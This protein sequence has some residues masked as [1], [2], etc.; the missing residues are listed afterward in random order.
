M[1]D[2]EIESLLDNIPPQVQ[3]VW[4]NL[5]L[6]TK[7]RFE[8]GSDKEDASNKDW[9]ASV[10]IKDR[11]N[12]N[13]M[14]GGAPVKKPED[15]TVEDF[16]PSQLE[17][18]YIFQSLVHYYSSRVVERYPLMFKA[19]KPHI[20]A[21]KPHQFQEAMNKK[22]EEYTGDLYTKSEK[23]MDDLLE[24]M[25]FFQQTTSTLKEMMMVQILVMR[26]K[27]SAETIKPRRTKLTAN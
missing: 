11:V 15:L 21:S 12:V 1:I 23:N 10:F 24:M 9:M 5:N 13:H 6:R 19:I 27:F 14:D 20:K 7:H 16:V 4:D 3:L 8:R 18:E 17:K 22:S 2:Q 25:S 26:R